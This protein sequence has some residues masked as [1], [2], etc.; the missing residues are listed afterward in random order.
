MVFLSIGAYFNYDIHAENIPMVTL[1]VLWLILFA[2]SLGL[3]LGIAN[4]FYPVVEKVIN[5]ILRILLFISALFYTLDMLPKRI[6]AIHDILL[7][8]PLIHFIEMIHGYYFH[9]LNDDY[10]DYNYMLLW[11]IPTLFIGLW[12]YTKLELRIT[13]L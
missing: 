2:S 7:Y 13:S 6:Q 11:T 3:F 8:N 4:Y 10:V 9:A 5:I 1:G 12:L